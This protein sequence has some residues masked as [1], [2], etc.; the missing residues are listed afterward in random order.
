M[1]AP[2]L[3]SATSWSWTA[4]LTT[5]RSLGSGPLSVEM[6]AIL[7]EDSVAEPNF[8]LFFARMR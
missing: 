4:V 5:P 3:W 8:S 7:E 1:I 6:H 2:T